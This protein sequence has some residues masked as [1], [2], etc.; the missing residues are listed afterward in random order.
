[1]LKNLNAR[2]EW[3]DERH[4]IKFQGDSKSFPLEEVANFSEYYSGLDV[5]EI[6]PGEGRQLHT[7]HPL[8]K[9]YSIADIS[10]VVVKR[11][12]GLV[13][14]VYHIRDYETDLD[15]KFD[16]ISLWYVFHHVLPEELDSF[17]CFI[18]RHLMIGGYLCCNL[19][20]NHGS[21]NAS[22]CNT[23]IY[24]LDETVDRMIKI[25]LQARYRSSVRSGNNYVMILEKVK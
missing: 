2:V 21:K 20:V 19:P 22:G 23:T 17:L 6:G 5:L 10:E 15:R 13:D 8:A 11:F 16:N 14:N 1:M 9:T 25:G 3:W 24:D 4:V 7:L 18:D 12:E